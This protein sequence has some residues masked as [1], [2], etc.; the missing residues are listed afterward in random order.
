MNRTHYQL[1][2]AGVVIAVIAAVLG[3]QFARRYTDSVAMKSQSAQRDVLYWYD[4]MTPNQ[5]FD[6]PGKSPSM[7]MQLVPRYADKNE[8]GQN[9]DA[10]SVHIDAA[11]TQNLGVRFTTVQRGMLM[12][13]IE[14]AGTLMFDQ[15]QITVV[16]TRTKGFVERVY[17]RAPGDVLRRGDALVDLLVPEWAGTQAEYLVLLNTGD[18]SLIHAAKERLRLAGM[19]DELINSIAAGHKVRPVITIRT[20]LAGVIDT[21]DIRE[22]MTV[23]AGMTLAKINGLEKIWVEAS[24]PEAQGALTGLGKQVEVRLTAYPG[25]NFKGEVIA[26]LPE[27]NADTR[28]L[29]LRI[30]LDNAQGKLKPGMF[31]AVHFDTGNHEPMLY[32]ASEAIIRSGTRNVVLVVDGKQNNQ[33]RFTPTVVQTGIETNGSTAILSGLSEGQQVVASGQFLIDSEANLNGVLARMS[34]GSAP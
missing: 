6:K 8:V 5:H 4:P 21:L 26:V 29:R 22:G 14:A 13:S 3:Y 17:A 32:V 23:D 1:V 33:W 24:I 11:T 2:F 19:S 7:D 16:Q 28:T 9:N 31:A 15:R 27:A 34:L 10:A 12:Q 20:P 25:K 18:V 30:E